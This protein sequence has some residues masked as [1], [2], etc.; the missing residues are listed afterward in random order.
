MC[1]STDAAI[2][3][4]IVVVQILY[5]AGALLCLTNNYV[6][7]VFIVLVQLNS[8]LAPRIFPLDRY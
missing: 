7:I 4:R 3:R 6:S 1:C 8:A 2:E 5:A